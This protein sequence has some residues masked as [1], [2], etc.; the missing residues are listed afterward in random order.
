MTTASWRPEKGRM[1]SEKTYGLCE[2]EM[3]RGRCADM[4]V[5]PQVSHG[6]SYKQM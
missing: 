4:W 1:A 5:S 2:R 6:V 3:N